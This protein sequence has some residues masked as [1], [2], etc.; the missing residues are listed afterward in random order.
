MGRHNGSSL[1]RVLPGVDAG[2]L[3]RMEEPPRGW[4]V[5]PPAQSVVSPGT[6]PRALARTGPSAQTRGER[7]SP[8][9][10]WTGPGPNHMNWTER[11]KEEGRKK[12]RP[13]LPPPFSLLC[14]LLISSRWETGAH[15]PREG[16]EAFLPGRMRGEAAPSPFSPV[17]GPKSSFL[18]RK[19]GRGD[20]LLQAS[21]PVPLSPAPFLPVSGCWGSAVGGVPLPSVSCPRG[22]S[23][24][25]AVAVSVPL[26]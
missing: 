17:A 21:P 25:R 6:R 4:A 5:F 7:A 26:G 15:S 14:N 9:H 24:P 12:S 20:S 18:V 8:P 13:K 19:E 10:K 1:L 22:P 2:D 3:P 23:A 11:G 16:G